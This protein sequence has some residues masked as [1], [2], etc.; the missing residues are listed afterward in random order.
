LPKLR[1]LT[2]S[3][4]EK[5]RV[6]SLLKQNTGTHVGTIGAGGDVDS[7]SASFETLYPKHLSQELSRICTLHLF[8]SLCH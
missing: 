3:H 4:T 5:R 7:L 1:S 2:K 8:W 6:R